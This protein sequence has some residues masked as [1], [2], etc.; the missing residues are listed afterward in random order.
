MIDFNNEYHNNFDTSIQLTKKAGYTIPIETHLLK[1]NTQLLNHSTLEGVYSIF[2]NEYGKANGNF[3]LREIKGQC[4]KVHS[5][6]QSVLLSKLNLQTII[7]VGYVKYN[8]Q[9]MFKFETIGNHN[10]RRVNQDGKTELDIH[11]WLTLPS[12]EVLDFTFIAHLAYVNYPQEKKILLEDAP[13]FIF[14]SGSAQK[15]FES[16]NCRYFPKFVGKD[17]L[18]QNGFIQIR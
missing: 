10:I 13:T 18:I 9:D 11:V 15:I 7:T 12:Y 5:E 2:Q 17:I 8:G 16:E 1:K 6:M 4:I 3:N 14:N